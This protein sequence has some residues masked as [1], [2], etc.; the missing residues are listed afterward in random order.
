MKHKRVHHDVAEGKKHDP[1]VQALKSACSGVCMI[2][3]LEI[4]YEGRESFITIQL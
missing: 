2:Y 4:W 3:G 1:F